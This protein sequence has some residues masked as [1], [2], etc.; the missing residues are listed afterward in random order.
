MT[1]ATEIPGPFRAMGESEARFRAR[2]KRF[3]AEQRLEAKMDAKAAADQR[4][5]EA[6]AAKAREA[7]VG[8]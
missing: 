6:R 3:A 2:Q 5:V 4:R 7:G 8:R 1:A